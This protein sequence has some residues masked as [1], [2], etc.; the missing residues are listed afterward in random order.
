MEKSL[1][2]KAQI[3]EAWP[4]FSSLN[5]WRSGVSAQPRWLPYLGGESLFIC[6]AKQMWRGDNIYFHNST[7]IW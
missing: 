2:F 4:F 7:Q 6:Q 3:W 5:S 1:L